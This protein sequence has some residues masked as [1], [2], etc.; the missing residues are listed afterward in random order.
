MTKHQG[1]NGADPQVKSSLNQRQAKETCNATTQTEKVIIIS[2]RKY[3]FKNKENYVQK[4]S[5]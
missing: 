5:K 4:R 3:F 2:L 1:V